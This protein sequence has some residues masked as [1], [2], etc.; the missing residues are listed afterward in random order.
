VSVFG[1]VQGE[2][3]KTAPKGYDRAHPEIGLLQLKQI[4]V[5]HHFTDREVL[6][7]DFREKVVGTCRAMRPFL[8]YLQGVLQ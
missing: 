7:G 1:A 2:R 4:L 5:F 6:A 8:D 3:L